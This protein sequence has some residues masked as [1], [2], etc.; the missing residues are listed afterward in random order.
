LKI[1]LSPFTH[2]TPKDL[3][4]LCCLASAHSLSPFAKSEAGVAAWRRRC[5]LQ[6]TRGDE[7][8]VILW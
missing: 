4:I 8:M 6:D 5:S 1:L 2:F 3:E 7:E